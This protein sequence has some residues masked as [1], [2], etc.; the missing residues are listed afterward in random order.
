VELFK[1]TCPL[2]YFHY[3][4]DM[5]IGNLILSGNVFL[6]PLAGVTDTPFRLLAK[7]YGACLVYTEMVSAEGL[8]RG[9]TDSLRLLYFREEERPIGV[10]IF[11][12]HP[13]SMAAACR[14]I[15]RTKPDLIDINFGCPVKK[16]VQKNGGAALLKDLKLLEKIVTTVSR[17]TRIPVTVKTRSGWDQKNIVALEVAKIAQDSGASAITIHPRTQKDNY[18]VKADWDVISRVKTEIK[19]PVIG[20][21]DIFTPQDARSMLDRTGCDAVMIGRGALGNPWIFSQIRHYLKFGETL[22]EP[23]VE[24]RI[25]VCLEHAELSVKEKGEYVGLITMRKHVA[26]YTMQ[27]PHSRELRQKVFT[28]GTLSE[29][30]RAFEDYLALPKKE[31]ETV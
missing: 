19:I 8:S 29:V 2:F 14:V 10:Q 18:S 13:D 1:D 23:S 26:W 6:A 3:I 17:S 16:V 30:K 27:L 20:S 21:G 31:C 28:L 11:G 25:R 9:N 15:E 12:S 24:E 7:R 5:E 22:P 4:V